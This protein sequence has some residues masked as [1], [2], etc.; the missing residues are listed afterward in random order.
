MQWEAFSTTPRH[1]LCA[2]LIASVHQVLDVS[3]P[4]Q[5]ERAP[6]QDICTQRP[7]EGNTNVTFHEGGSSEDQKSWR[8]I[9]TAHLRTCTGVG[10]PMLTLCPNHDNAKWE[11][12]LATNETPVMRMSKSNGE[13]TLL[14]AIPESC[15]EIGTK[16]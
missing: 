4:R 14:W 3:C 1:A 10:I 11:C 7:R 16:F 5:W 9:W 13:T 15:Q 8:R 6:L 2:Q 12:Q